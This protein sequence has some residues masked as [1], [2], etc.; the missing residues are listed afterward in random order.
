MRIIF[1]SLLIIQGDSSSLHM[2]PFLGIDT[3]WTCAKDPIDVGSIKITRKGSYNQRRREVRITWVSE[4]PPE[5]VN[6]FIGSSMNLDSLFDK[7]PYMKNY[8]GDI[9]E[10][11]SIDSSGYFLSCML[12]RVRRIE[13]VNKYE[14]WDRSEIAGRCHEA[15]KLFAGIHF[16]SSAWL[17]LLHYP[18]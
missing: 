11:D 1:L 6:K 17:S 13:L 9:V 16:P 15:R 10:G 12:D 18:N 3:R 7:D 2:A 4:C 8:S 14:V 5:L